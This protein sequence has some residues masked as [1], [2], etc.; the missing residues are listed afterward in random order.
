[1]AL[2]TLTTVDLFYFIMRE[3]PHKQKFIEIAFGWGHVTPLHEIGG[4]LGR[5]S[6]RH[7]HL[8]SH[9]SMVMARVWSGPYIWVP[10]WLLL[11]ISIVNLIGRRWSPIPLF[12]FTQNFFNKKKKYLTHT[13]MLVNWIRT[14]SIFGCVLFVSVDNPG[15][16]VRGGGGFRCLVSMTLMA[17]AC[18]AELQNDICHDLKDSFSVLRP[19]TKCLF[20]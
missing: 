2:R 3:D 20:D 19:T 7:F 12:I 5:P 10:H 13:T 8:G 4:V 18:K 17:Q 9:T 15:S 14:R 6:F 11:T 1:M 16:R